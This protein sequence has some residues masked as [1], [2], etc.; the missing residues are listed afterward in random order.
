M[1]SLRQN[2]IWPQEVGFLSMPWMAGLKSV[3]LKAARTLFGRV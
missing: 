1:G 3:W 2:V